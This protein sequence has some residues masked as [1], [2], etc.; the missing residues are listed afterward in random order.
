M[1]SLKIARRLLTSAR[2]SSP[3]SLDPRPLLVRKLKKAVVTVDFKKSILN[4]EPETFFCTAE[5]PPKFITSAGNSCWECSGVFYENYY[6]YRFFVFWCCAPDA[7]A[8][9]VVKNQS[10]INSVQ[11]RGTIK[12]S[13]F[14]RGICKNQRYLICKGSREQAH[15]RE[16]NPTRNRQQSGPF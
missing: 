5:M 16:S 9:V 7:S 12:T 3:C 4:S 8:P 13:G 15:L 1:P 11:T 2:K 6:Q 10:P 14:T